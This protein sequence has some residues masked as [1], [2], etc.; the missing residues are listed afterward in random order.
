MDLAAAAL[1]AA[2]VAAR[3]ELPETAYFTTKRG[4]IRDALVA[5]GVSETIERLV[6]AL[7]PV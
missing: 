5:D 3:V 6:D 2:A 1:H 7:L 4:L